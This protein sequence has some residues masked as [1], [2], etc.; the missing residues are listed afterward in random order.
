[1][2]K[3]FNSGQ[4]NAPMGSSLPTCSGCRH[5]CCRGHGYGV[6]YNN[7]DS[8]MSGGGMC[9]NGTG[10]GAG[11]GM[12]GG[13]MSMGGGGGMS[14]G[15]GGG[16]GMGGGGGMGMGTGGMNT[17]MNQ[18]YM[19]MNAGGMPMS[20]GGMGMPN[21]KYKMMNSLKD[22]APSLYSETYNYLNQN[23]MRPV[24][25]E[26]Y[27]D[28]KS[29]TPNN[30]VGNSPLA[31]QIPALSGA[32]QNPALLGA[33]DTEPGQNQ[34][35][36]TGA[37]ANTMNHNAASGEPMKNMGNE[38]LNMMMSRHNPNANAWATAN[39]IQGGLGKGESML[40]DAPQ[41]P[42]G[43]I[44]LTPYSPSTGTNENKPNTNIP[45][46][47]IGMGN[48]Q[49]ANPTTHYVTQDNMYS[50]P[51]DANVYNAQG[52]VMNGNMTQNMNPGIQNSPPPMSTAQNAGLMNSRPGVP[53]SGPNNYGQ[54][55][56]GMRTFQNMFPGI[57]DGNDLGF[58]PM[59]I[60]IQMNPANQKRAAMDNIHKMM[61]NQPRIRS[62]AMQPAIQGSNAITSQ[63]SQQQQQDSGQLNSPVGQQNLTTNQQPL[64]N[65]APNPQGPTPTGQVGQTVQE[66][67]Q[68]VNPGALVPQNQQIY[69]AL[70]RTPTINQ[71]MQ[72]QQTPQQVQGQM[73]PQQLQDQIEYQQGQTLSHADTIQQRQALF[74]NQQRQIPQQQ[75]IDPATG[76]PLNYTTGG[77][78]N[79]QI[80]NQGMIKEP[81]YPAETSRNIVSY[82]Q[83]HYAHNYN[84][85]GQP[86]N[87]ER[88]D[89]Y[90][91][92]IPPL[93][94]TLSPQDTGAN[95]LESSVKNTTSKTSLAANR[96]MGQAPSKSQLRHIYRQYKAGHAGMQQTI[97]PPQGG[98][99]S[100]GKL[101]P[102]GGVNAQ[103]NYNYGQ[104]PIERVGGDTTQNFNTV[105]Q[106]MSVKPEQNI[107]QR[108]DVNQ[109]NT[110]QGD[111]ITEKVN[112]IV[113]FLW[114]P[115]KYTILIFK[116]LFAV[117]N[118]AIKWKK[119][120]R[121]ARY[122]FYK[123][124]KFEWMEFSRRL[125]G[126]PF[127]RLPQPSSSVM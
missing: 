3:L 98:S 53:L 64:Q 83:P 40:I 113:T 76:A 78:S 2:G 13:G 88:A 99:Q 34:S 58:D 91:T 81:V 79:A 55:S 12:G 72:Q 75:M 10:M 59:A 121:I 124:Q 117:S 45:E 5:G 18:G 122:A 33:S 95:I 119:Q 36:L 1:M 116:F 86:I 93:P 71:P 115:M 69:T 24:V 125:H 107:G 41:S 106:P 68:A 8:S 35:M 60:A 100:D 82:A 85:L 39:G 27:Q 14:M 44:G 37:M 54:H 118:D 114:E 48:S 80:Q 87:L 7:G 84:T 104:A 103:I 21:D 123:I 43:Q 110:P 90:H 96:V 23:L 97:R 6:H 52:N 38:I 102:P 111:I 101:Y 31:K 16:M 112:N 56:M 19:G 9:R 127:L 50:Q 73:Q 57:A 22:T 92:P 89:K 74:N 61:N 32:G 51:P 77:D 62:N 49:M 47:N 105:Q 28:L 126:R 20:G 4:E 26:M 120:K 42:H 109:T 66:Q 17:G 11:Y 94:Q 70:S 30:S 15:G 63:L 65:G 67:N 25:H 29:L 46:A 108:G